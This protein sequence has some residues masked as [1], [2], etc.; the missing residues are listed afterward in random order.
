M[1]EPSGPAAPA[2]GSVRYFTLLYAPAT[3]R[4]ELNTL[5]A[6]ADEIGSAPADSADHTV[7]HVR[8]EWW[9]REAERFARGAPEH[10]WLRALLSRHPA[11]RLLNLQSL[12][13]AAAIDLATHTLKSQQPQ[14]LQRALF[15]L[16]A[17]ALCGQAL[18]PELQQAI[19][20]LGAG[21]RE[22][23]SGAN[24]EPA[25]APL[26]DSLR[27]IDASLQPALAP[28]LVWLALVAERPHR[29]LPLLDGVADNLIAWKAARRAAR[30]RFELN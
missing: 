27:K 9:R 15:V 10:P 13:D 12:V 23:E 11:T 30:G 5:L 4:E 1:S 25:R 29:R 18:T 3:L 8:L 7:A 22:L 26:R 2:P 16:V 21:V 20:E 19:G 24:G 6:L 14:A 17:D 28:L